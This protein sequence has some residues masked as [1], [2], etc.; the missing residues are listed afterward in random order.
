[1]M[2]GQFTPGH[3]LISMASGKLSIIEVEKLT[4]ISFH[5]SQLSITVEHS[6]FT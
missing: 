3:Q 4:K 2:F 6:N 5:S 1:M